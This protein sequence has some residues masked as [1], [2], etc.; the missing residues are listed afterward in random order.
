MSEPPS[1]PSPHLL[2]AFILGLYVKDIQHTTRFA[3]QYS[4]GKRGGKHPPKKNIAIV[5][6]VIVVMTKIKPDTA[7]SEVR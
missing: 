5:G 7:H 2:R 4:S 6:A 3:S 1:P